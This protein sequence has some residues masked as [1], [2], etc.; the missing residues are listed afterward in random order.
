LF[1]QVTIGTP[2]TVV[3]QT[4]KL[5]WHAGDLYLEVHPTWEQLDELDETGRFAPENIPELRDAVLA[6]AGNE[7]G[8]VNWPL[9]YS[10]ARNRRG[11]PMRITL[12]AQDLTS[13]ALDFDDATDPFD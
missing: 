13:P 1:R 7:A 4:V 3:S 8:L 2:V 6:E 9:V 11:L 10:I 12:R 5:G